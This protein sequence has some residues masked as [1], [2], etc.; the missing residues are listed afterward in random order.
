L[1]ELRNLRL[2]R[3]FSQADLSAK[4]GVAEFTISEIEG[5]KRPNPRPSTLRKLAQ[6]L[7]VEV[8]DLYGEPDNPLGAAPPPTEQRSFN[9]LLA[10]EQRPR[11]LQGWRI[12]RAFVYGLAGRWR[13]SPPKTSA[14]IEPIFDT[15]TTLVEQGVFEPSQTP[16]MR[17]VEEFTL[18]MAGFERLNEIASNVEEDEQTKHQRNAVVR[19]IREKFSA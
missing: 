14:E 2:R 8:A 1:R 10:E 4:T 16:D 17:E 5:G 18:I 6:G 15:L 19:D 12:F 9:H 7:G 11:D 3:G 13:E